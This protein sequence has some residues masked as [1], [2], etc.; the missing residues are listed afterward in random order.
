M[1]LFDFDGDHLP[2]IGAF[3]PEVVKVK[4]VKSI[5]SDIELFQNFPNPFNAITEIR[6]E[7]KSAGNVLL[8]VYDLSG[9]EIDK[10]VEQKQNSGMHVVNWDAS[11]FASGIYFYRLNANNHLV[12]GKMVLLR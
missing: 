3:N 6:Y 4:E 1:T 12:T 5:P 11:N 7:M 2:S 8:T 10:L 9:R